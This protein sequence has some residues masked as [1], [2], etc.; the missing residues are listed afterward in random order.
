VGIPRIL[1]YSLYSS[2]S[3][4]SYAGA[5]QVLMFPRE[6]KI[7]R[8]KMELKVA[9]TDGLQSALHNPVR[10]ARGRLSALSISHRKSVL[11][12]AS[13]WARRA[14]NGQKRRSPAW[15]VADG[16]PAETHRE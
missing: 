4:L 8:N 9:T 1:S 14:L 7:S 15:A 16:V 2:Y 13:V 12:G 6:M 11:Y 3:R 5:R 10:A